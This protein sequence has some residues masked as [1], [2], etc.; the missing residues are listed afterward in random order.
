MEGAEVR[1]GDPHGLPEI[2][3][4]DSPEGPLQLARMQLAALPGIVG[5]V[6][7]IV[8]PALLRWGDS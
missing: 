6:Q 5:A 8:P 7:R 4:I 1:H 2:P 3:V